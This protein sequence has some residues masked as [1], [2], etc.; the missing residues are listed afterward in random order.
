MPSIRRSTKF[1]QGALGPANPVPALLDVG[2]SNA[3]ASALL[4]ERSPSS[5]R[6]G[7]HGCSPE[8]DMRV[9]VEGEPVRRP[10]AVGPERGSIVPHMAD[11]AE[12]AIAVEAKSSV[13]PLCGERV[14]RRVV[15][16]PYRMPPQWPSLG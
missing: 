4:S 1:R 7:S 13:D 3:P 10:P 5:P 11:I 15:A 8:Q 6:Y 2:C 16:A 12:V 9:R 14:R